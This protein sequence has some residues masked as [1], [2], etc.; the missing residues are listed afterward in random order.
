MS[1]SVY[2]Y[3]HKDSVFKNPTEMNLMENII[4]DLFLLLMG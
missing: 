1:S 4:G 3:G 2:W